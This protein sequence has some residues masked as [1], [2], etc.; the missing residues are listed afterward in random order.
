MKKFLLFFSAAFLVLQN[1]S[2]QSYYVQPIVYQPFPFYQGASVLLADDVCSAPI[3]IGFNFC[4]F[5]QS[6]NTVVVAS[7]GYITFDLS[8]AGQYSP[9]PIN[10][11]IPNPA[12]PLNAIMCPWQDINPGNGG[13]IYVATYGDAPCRKFVVSYFM[14]PMFDCDFMHFSNQVVLYESSNVIETYIESKPLCL[15]W[16]NGASLHGLQ[17]GDGTQAVVIPGR[18]FPALWEA[19][20]DA[21]RFSPLT[22]GADTNSC[23]FLTE[24]SDY[25]LLTGKVFIDSVANCSYDSTEYEITNEMVTLSPG[26]WVDFTDAAGNYRFF[27]FDTGD[28]QVNLNG[29]SYMQVTCTNG[30]VN[31]PSL[32]DTVDVPLPVENLDCAALFASLDFVVVRPCSSEVVFV[33]LENQGTIH[34]GLITANVYLP[35]GLTV[36]SSSEV[37]AVVNDTLVFILPGLNP[38]ESETISITVL[39]DCGLQL[40]EMLCGNLSASIQNESCPEVISADSACT[41]VVNSY[42]PNDKRFSFGENIPVDGYFT[43]ETITP[44][45]SLVYVIRFQNTGTAVAYDVRVMDEIPATLDLTS[46]RMISA[47]HNYQLSIT[48][49]TIVWTF[50]NI[51]LPDSASDQVNSIGFLKFSINQNGN[52]PGTDILNDASIFFD[53]NPPVITLDAISHVDVVTSVTNQNQEGMKIYPNPASQQVTVIGDFK[54]GYRLLLFDVTGKQI[55]NYSL[56]EKNTTIDI[57][58]IIDGFYLYRIVDEKQNAVESGKIQIVR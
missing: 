27:I 13:M 19:Y 23:P 15:Q 14:V 4:F 17:N 54:N 7:N 53:F 58:A 6:F 1:S 16:N 42:D 56:I 25:T 38:S 18:N 2:A 9:W 34:T 30:Q 49:Q 24:V 10:T 11:P 44:P 46:F 12:A 28:Y 36:L 52:L 20:S 41:I 50:T 57:S 47:S 35:P 48:G 32:N 31:I 29:P 26:N 55:K 33:T 21:Y 5:G 22:C 43:E 8:Q 3:P 39:A 45:D 40:G 51:M 37:Y